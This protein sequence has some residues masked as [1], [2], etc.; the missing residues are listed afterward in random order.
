MTALQAG[1]LTRDEILDNIKR[2][3]EAHRAKLKATRAHVVKLNEDGPICSDGAN[4]FLTD[5]GLP[6]LW[7]YEEMRRQ[8]Y[9]CVDLH[10]GDPIAVPAP[11]TPKNPARAAVSTL[12]R[13]HAKQLAMFA[14]QIEGMRKAAVAAYHDDFIELRHLQAWLKEIGEPP[15][16][17]SFLISGEVTVR[18]RYVTE[19]DAGE[20]IDDIE[21][22]L[23]EELKEKA[24]D[25][26]KI[27][28]K[29][30]HSNYVRVRLTAEFEDA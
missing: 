4:Q 22:R 9:D 3:A 25:S 15:Y 30:D 11:K 8:V 29:D 24:E 28:P 12:I 17:E 10:A 23:R 20:D 16:K 6:G 27:G 1:E 13:Y 26:F 7:T 19:G 14:D 18:F 5:H 21:F 2:D